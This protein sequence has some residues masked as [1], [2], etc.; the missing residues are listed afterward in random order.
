M[1]KHKFNDIGFDKD[2]NISINGPSGVEAEVYKQGY[3]K[4]KQKHRKE[5]Q[6]ARIET[7]KRIA[8]ENNENNLKL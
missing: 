5:A 8:L 7:N 6:T 3:N 4:L 1:R 2:M